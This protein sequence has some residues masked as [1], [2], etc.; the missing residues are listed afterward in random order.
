[1]RRRWPSAAIPCR[2]FLF[3]AI[4]LHLPPK[5]VA[6]EI[7]SKSKLER[8][9]K[10]SNSDSLDCEKKIVLN[11]AVPSGSSGG[12]ASIV[13]ELVE[14]EENNTQKMQTIRSPPIITI[15]K[16]AAYALYELTYIRDVSYKPEEFYVKTRKCKP[17]A[18]AHVVKICER[19]QDEKGNIIEH[20]QPICCPCGPRR[21]VPS[22]CGNVFDKLTKGKAN[23]AHCLRFPGFMS[24][25]LEGGHLAL[26]SILKLRKDLCFRK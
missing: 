20:T 5:I 25:V 18:S 17:D 2:L 3:F 11:M 26:V 8:C 16:S 13:A 1:M 14:V 12:E 10:E 24:S 23:T 9:V 4:L 21:R 7:L 6:V 22:S 15:K 19:L